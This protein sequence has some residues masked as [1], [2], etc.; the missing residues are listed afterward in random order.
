MKNNRDGLFMAVARQMAQESHCIRVK[1]GAVITI[2]DRI[3][4]S[5]WNGTPAGF[6]NC[7]D[8]AKENGGPVIAVAD[9]R[10]FSK[11]EVHAEANSIAHAAKNGV[12]IEGGIIYVTRSPCFDCAKLIISSGISRVVFQEMYDRDDSLSFM[13]ECGIIVEQICLH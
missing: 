4:S 13:R 1:V 10:S 7:D 3:V 8:W 6:K 5:G 11:F 9:H 12:T 2:N